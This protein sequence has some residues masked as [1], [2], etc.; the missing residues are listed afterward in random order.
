M[1]CVCACVSREEALRR[2]D[3]SSRGL[4]RAWA[5]LARR[6][7]RQAAAAGQAHLELIHL[8]AYFI[9]SSGEAGARGLLIDAQEGHAA[10]VDL[11]QASWEQRE[12]DFACAIDHAG[13][14][15]LARLWRLANRGNPASAGQPRVELIG[16]PYWVYYYRRAAGKLDAKLVDAVS[17]ARAGPRTKIALLA[18]LASQHHARRRAS[19]G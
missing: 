10:A 9:V 16:Y 5:W 13:A 6:V 15:E 19:A 7:F 4:G 3:A 1:R 14:L 11:S 18:A 17:G 12:P 8:P 2:L